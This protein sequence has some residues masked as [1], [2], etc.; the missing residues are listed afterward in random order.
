MEKI[1]L[2]SETN[3]YYRYETHYPNMKILSVAVEKFEDRIKILFVD[4]KWE[5]IISNEYE[6]TIY[7]ETSILP[8]VS[9]EEFENFINFFSPVSVIKPNKEFLNQIIDLN[10]NDFGVLNCEMTGDYRKINCQYYDFESI[11]LLTKSGMYRIDKIGNKF[12]M[13]NNFTAIKNPPEIFKEMFRFFCN[14]IDFD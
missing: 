6:N 7:M 11:C 5:I 14:K 4:I 2:I 1:K 10:N 8:Y 9:Y 13:S 12:Q 3:N